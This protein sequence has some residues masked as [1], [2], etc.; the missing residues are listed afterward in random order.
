MIVRIWGALSALSMAKLVRHNEGDDSAQPPA[1][2][3]YA[4]VGVA[5]LIRL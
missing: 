1:T 3:S 4:A 2:W 5:T